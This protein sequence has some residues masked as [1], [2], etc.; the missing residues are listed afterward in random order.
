MATAVQP[1]HRSRPH[2]I[3]RRRR[4]VAYGLLGPGGVWLLVF[5]LVPVGIMAYTSLKSGGVMAGGFTFTW[6]WS[7]YATALEGRQEFLLRSLAFASLTTLGTV[8]LA[9]PAVYWIAFHGGRFTS[10]LLFA[11][12]L[13]YFVSFMIRT[14]QW[15]F[16]LGDNGPVL[17]FMK[18]LGVVPE[19][20]HVLATAGAVVFGLIYNYL[21]FAALP[22]FVAL[23]R[24]DPSL[25][26]G[27]QD[28]YAT[29]AGAFWKIVFPLSMPGIFAATLL[30]FV[31]A[32]G[33]YVEAEILGSP[34]TKM[35]G[36]IIQTE[37]L[38]R[39]R[40]PIAAAL[41]MVLMLTMVILTSIYAKFLGTEDETLSAARI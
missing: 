20:F 16:I 32:T 37:F 27:A 36:N 6:E 35:I 8:L 28:L 40:Y 38:G 13:P 1:R 10:S 7:N 19:D 9:Y 3:E 26:E 5:F 29:P 4:R 14:V 15:K 18:D 31:P 2:G 17:S 24:I 39:A 25:V 23:D 33:D 30:T 22:L 21:P 12:L 34:T 41:A 11:I